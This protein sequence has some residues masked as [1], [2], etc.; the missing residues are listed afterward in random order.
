MIQFIYYGAIAGATIGAIVAK[1]LQNK[2]QRGTNAIL[3]PETGR[4]NDTET[5]S[6]PGG[7]RRDERPDSGGGNEPN[8]KPE[9]L[10]DENESSDGNANRSVST[11]GGRSDASTAN[12]RPD[13]G[14][15]EKG[16]N[17]E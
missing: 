3:M 15:T 10:K 16:G 14:L 2:N 11:G 5:N 1:R 12:P 17:D 7:N 9:G 4:A 8:S 6:P 13:P